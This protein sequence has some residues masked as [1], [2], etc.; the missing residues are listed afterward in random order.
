MARYFAAVSSALRRSSPR[1]ASIVALF[2]SAALW[3]KA[4]L[5]FICSTYSAFFFSNFSCSCTNCSLS[6]WNSS[7][8]FDVISLT[9]FDKIIEEMNELLPQ[10]FSTQPPQLPS[11]CSPMNQ[12][13]IAS[14][15]LCFPTQNTFTSDQYIKL[16][17]T[18]LVE[19]QNPFVSLE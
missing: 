17:Q 1:L 3:I 13:Q 15:E 14:Y 11:W 4:I 10:S 2:S 19:M 9:K 7:T 5:F 18:D 6:Y 16:Y 8:G 12:R